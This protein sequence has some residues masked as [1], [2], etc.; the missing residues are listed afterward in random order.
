VLR[1]A[2]SM[3]ELQKLF[4]FLGAHAGRA[5]AW[6]YYDATDNLR[7]TFDAMASQEDHHFH[8]SSIVTDFSGGTLTNQVVVGGTDTTETVAGHVRTVHVGGTAMAETF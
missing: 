6:S 7:L 3:L 1:A 2:S 8:N 4:G 5:T